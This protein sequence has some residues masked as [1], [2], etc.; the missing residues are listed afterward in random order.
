MAANTSS[1]RLSSYLLPP[2][3]GDGIYEFGSINEAIP[4][5]PVETDKMT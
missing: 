1:W 3:Q 5:F 4:L 2:T